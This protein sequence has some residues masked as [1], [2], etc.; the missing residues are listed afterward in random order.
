MHW[1]NRGVTGTA[2]HFLH[3][4]MHLRLDDLIP[5]VT[6]RR[7]AVEVTGIRHGF[8]HP[9]PQAVEGGFVDGHVVS[10]R[11]VADASGN[12]GC[13]ESSSFL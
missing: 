12:R 5:I 13:R 9:A 3:R 11:E 8:R 10:T 6:I 2:T 7:H 4:V 1:D